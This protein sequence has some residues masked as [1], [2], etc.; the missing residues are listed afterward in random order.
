MGWKL[1]RIDVKCYEVFDFMGLPYRDGETGIKSYTPPHK[2]LADLWFCH[3]TME[4]KQL[5]NFSVGERQRIW[6]EINSC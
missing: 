6:K 5:K 3:P 1:L 2:H 4:P